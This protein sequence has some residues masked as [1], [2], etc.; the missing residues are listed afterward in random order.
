MSTRGLAEFANSIRCY[1][2][3]TTRNI[4]IY[5]DRPSKVTGQPCIHIEFRYKSAAFCRTRGVYGVT[6]R[7]VQNRTLSPTGA[8]RGDN[9]ETVGWLTP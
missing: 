8:V 1:S 9:A 7:S 2:D 3:P 5:S 4:V 6:T